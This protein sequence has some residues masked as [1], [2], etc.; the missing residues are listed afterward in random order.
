MIFEDEDLDANRMVC[1]LLTW[2]RVISVLL[3]AGELRQEADCL[4]QKEGAEFIVN[5]DDNSFVR[6][7][8]IAHALAKGWRTLGESASLKGQRVQ[9]VKG[10]PISS[11][12]K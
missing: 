6:R 7:E 11:T 5:L 9:G 3:L 12:W 10:M 2:A 8:D 1:G 4:K